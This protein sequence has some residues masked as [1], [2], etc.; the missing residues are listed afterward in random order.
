MD[1]EY[2]CIVL[3]TGLTECILSGLLSV[4]GKKVLHIDRNDYYGAECASL[5]LDQLWGKFRN[6]QTP[7]ESIGRNRDYNVDLVPKFMMANGEIIRFL[8]HT[9]VTRYLEFKQIAGSYVY[10]SGKIYKVPATEMEAVTSSLFG[11]FEKRR[12]KKFFE[13]VQNYREEDP[14]THQGLNLDR[15]TSAA[16]FNKFGL[17][18]ASQEFLGHAMALHLDDDYLNQPARETIEKIRLYASSM[19]RYGLSP[20]LYPLYGLGEMPQGFARLS[21]IYGGTYM[22]DKK[23]DELVYD[24]EGK[25]CGVKSGDEVAKT[26][27][28]I[29]DPSYAQDKI[30]KV[31]SVVRAI[32]LLNHPI[33]NTSDADSVQIVVPQ[34]Q[35]GRKH[36][37]YIAC[38][39]SAHN[40]C[41]KDKWLAIVSTIVE[42]DKPEQELE[43]GIKLLGPVQEKFISVSPL[44]EPVADGKADNVFISRSYDATSHF[45]T[46]CEDV[47]DLYK[48]ITGQPLVLKQR[49]TQAQEQAEMAA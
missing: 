44:E 6:G 13:F 16:V 38:V 5:N 12:A 29:C 26:K 27:L 8:T 3:G 22:L 41:A 10:A 39:S 25:V 23:V 31:G 46:V 7:P 20:Y 34:G 14:A 47:H 9:D 15:D 4:E 37:V 48:R 45:E 11:L 1:E 40:V 35:I 28:V 24:A 49:S 42:S 33:P 18:P 36:D 32:C 17:A 21:A 43:A 19:A 30:R 2:D